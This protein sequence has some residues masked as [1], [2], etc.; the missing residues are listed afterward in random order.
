[1]ATGLQSGND[2]HYSDETG[3]TLFINPSA[4]L[5]THLK[6]PLSQE[7]MNKRLSKAYV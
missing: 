1:M 2:R 5:P 3:T 6:S 7:S 4:L